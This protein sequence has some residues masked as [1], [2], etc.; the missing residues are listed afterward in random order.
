MRIEITI[1]VLAALAA[2]SDDADDVLANCPEVPG[3]LR[4]E[5]DVSGGGAGELAISGLVFGNKIS[6]D[7][8][9]F[10]LREGTTEI[11]HIEFDKLIA[12]GGSSAARGRFTLAASSLDVGNCE[13]AGFSG[14]LAQSEDGELWGFRLEGLHAAPYCSGPAVSGSITAC[15]RDTT[16]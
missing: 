15:Y 16:P 10:V 7:P 5:H 14:V 9:L 6:D 2:C 1:G 11:V 8:G 3:A 4:F 13:T 12:H